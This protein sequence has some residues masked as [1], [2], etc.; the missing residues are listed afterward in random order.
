MH[1]RMENLY[2]DFILSKYRL[3]AFIWDQICLILIIWNFDPHVHF[4]M[5]MP[6]S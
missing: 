5:K 1:K 6:I 3:S 2:F 4:Y